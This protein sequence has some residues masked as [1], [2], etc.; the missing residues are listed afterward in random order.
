MQSFPGCL[1]PHVEKRII[2]RLW[3]IQPVSSSTFQQ[4]TAVRYFPTNNGKGF[5]W[6]V[7]DDQALHEDIYADQQPAASS[8]RLLQ[9]GIPVGEESPFV[10]PV[11]PRTEIAQG[12]NCHSLTL[13]VL[14]TS[15]E[16]F[17][18][19]LNLSFMATSRRNF[20]IALTHAM[21][22]PAGTHYFPHWSWRQ[23]F[24]KIYAHSH[25]VRQLTVVTRSIGTD[26][27]AT[28]QLAPSATNRY[29]FSRRVDTRS[30]E[31]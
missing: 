23:M 29:L 30:K 26:F 4:A 3:Q 10:D 24:R 6:F 5:D 22:S 7:G 1:Q 20:S 16:C 21:N 27:T 28:W 9:G 14:R 31:S 11:E 18:L 25:P 2:V 15:L 19:R 12:L 17:D 13:P 8:V